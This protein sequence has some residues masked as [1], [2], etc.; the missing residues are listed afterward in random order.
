MVQSVTAGI[1][2]AAISVVRDYAVDCAWVTVCKAWTS[3]LI[4]CAHVVAKKQ[5]RIY[6]VTV[7][8]TPHSALT[9]DNLCN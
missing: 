9:L 7:L 3:A 1:F 4:D 2:M 5:K 8:F 6:F